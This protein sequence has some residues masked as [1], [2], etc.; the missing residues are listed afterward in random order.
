MALKKCKN[1][2]REFEGNERQFCSWQCDE[3]YK[4]NLNRPNDA[5]KNDE[6]TDRLNTD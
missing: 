3:A 6:H 1:C 2:D 4:R 5:V